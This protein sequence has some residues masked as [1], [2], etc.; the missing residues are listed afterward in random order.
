MAFFLAEGYI[1]TRNVK[2][3]AARIFVFAV[4]S[5]LPFCYISTGGWLPVEI[6]SGNVSPSAIGIPLSGGD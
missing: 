1:H 2:K 5:I 4:L 6:V 3:Y